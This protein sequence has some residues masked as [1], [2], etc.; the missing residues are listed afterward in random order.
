MKRGRLPLT[1]LRSFEAAGRHLSFTRAAEE[2]FV[3][4]AA[5]SRQIRE[6][7]SL[8]G[9]VLFERQHRKVRLTEPGLTLLKQL[10]KSFDEIDRQLAE[11]GSA[12][13]ETVLR[14]SVEPAFATSWLVPRLARF[15]TEHPHIDVF[16]DVDMALAEFRGS[17]IALAVRYSATT[18]EWPR[19][20]AER[21]F[22]IQA[23]PVLS[24][25]LLETGPPLSAPGDLAGYTLLHDE[26]RDMWSRWFSAAGLEDFDARHG[27]IFR[28]AAHALQAAVLGHGVALGDLLLDGDDLAAG[29]LVS[30]FEVEVPYGSYFLVAPDFEGLDPAAKA[31]ADWLRA[32]LQKMPRRWN[33][34][35][36]R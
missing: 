6:L 3:T 22:D 25:R 33:L 14:I 28:D 4:Q 13:T 15:R 24:P 21:V 2:L 36:T 19:V 34:E 7:E 5:V 16:V 17:D 12:P 27:P 32:E 10:T 1:A 8:V 20:Q 29:R 11:I 35:P 9:K 18:A 26:S 23:R 30:P 31:F